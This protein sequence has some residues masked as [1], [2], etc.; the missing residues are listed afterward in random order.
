MS[1][2]PIARWCSSSTPGAAAAVLVLLTAC[3][4]GP[5]F[6]P[7]PS[8]TPTDPDD[9]GD[10]IPASVDC[11]DLSEGHGP[12]AVEWCD[13]GDSD[14]DG[15]IDD[16]CA[17]P[18]QGGWAPSAW[19]EG[20]FDLNPVPLDAFFASRRDPTPTVDDRTTLPVP[21]GGD[22]SVRTTFTIDSFDPTE[23]RG[24][25]SS[26]GF[27]GLVFTGD[28]GGENH[29]ASP[30][31]YLFPDTPVRSRIRGALPIGDGS[32]PVI[33][34][35]S[36]DLFVQRRAGWIDLW[37]DGAWRGRRRMPTLD[38]ANPLDVVDP[39]PLAAIQAT[40]VNCSATVAPVVVSHR[41]DDTEYPEPC[42][43][44]LKN[45]DFW[46]RTAGVADHCRSTIGT[47]RWSRTV[48]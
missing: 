15:V 18:G 14:C 26:F 7:P 33:E 8:D 3:P 25:G 29:W 40:C 2:E 20:P 9:D 43:D 4:P 24:D 23:Y 27:L 31:L 36:F 10:G 41:V 5:G 16:R 12:G 47:P 28:D 21:A 34:G 13:G 17:G 46:Y 11:N 30:G 35:R 38:P 44:L 37:I 42:G 39:G 1:T 22:W 32:T 48:T 6:R 45:P 19:W